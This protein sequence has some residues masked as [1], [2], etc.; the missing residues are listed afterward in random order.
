[1]RIQ[2]KHTTRDMT[3]EEEAEYRASSENQA[4]DEAQTLEILLGGA[5]E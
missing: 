5:A 3:P 2:E 4:L 1:M